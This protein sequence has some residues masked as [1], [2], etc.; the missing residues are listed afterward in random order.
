VHDSAATSGESMHPALVG[1]SLHNGRAGGREATAT[2][3]HLVGR[4]ALRVSPTQVPGTRFGKPMTLDSLEL[5]LV[6]GITTAR[7]NAH[8][9]YVAQGRVEGLC[10]LDRHLLSIL[11]D[12][13]AGA[14]RFTLLDLELFSS[15]R[16][17]EFWVYL[18]EWRRAVRDEVRRLP[19]PRESL[20]AIEAT[21]E[22]SIAD[23]QTLRRQ[24]LDFALVFGLE[25]RVTSQL[26][27]A[28]STPEGA[29]LL[30]RASSGRRTP[31]QSLR[32]VMSPAYPFGYS[33]PSRIGF[34][35]IPLNARPIIVVANEE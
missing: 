6:P 15:T 17:W 21:V 31:V 34:T 35:P 9:P 12:R 8:S 23:G 19:L 5:S 4:G 10:K 2:L 27:R 28:S 13:I 32:R 26:D 14:P 30:Y 29:E 7:H 3:I 1:A 22:K 18:R 24:T 33:P 16:P 25:D 20:L 11:F